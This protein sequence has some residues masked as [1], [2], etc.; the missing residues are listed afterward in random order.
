LLAPESVDV[1]FVRDIEADNIEQQVE[2]GTAAGSGS[3]GDAN[4]LLRVR[5][6]H[7]LN[8]FTKLLERYELRSHSEICLR[9]RETHDERSMVGEQ[10][11]IPRDPLVEIREFFLN[12]IEYLLQLGTILLIWH[13][14]KE[15]VECHFVCHCLPFKKRMEI[16][17]ICGNYQIIKLSN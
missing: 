4:K 1:F 12:I 2:H 3:P 9:G 16:G 13:C 5:E 14:F 6:A 10:R 15:V 17:I 7:L 8:L 11:L